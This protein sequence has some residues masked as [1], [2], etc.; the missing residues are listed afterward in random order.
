MTELN[1][2]KDFRDAI[3]NNDMI[4]LKASFEKDPTRFGT[5]VE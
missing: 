2:R 3:D 5:M 1:T 4:S